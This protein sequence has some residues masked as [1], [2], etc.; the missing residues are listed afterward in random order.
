MRYTKI[1]LGDKY[2]QKI[3]KYREDTLR[4]RGGRRIDK[5]E[6]ESQIMLNHIGNV[7][8]IMEKMESILF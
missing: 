1:Y 4:E 5:L 7:S 2:K 3:G 6:R 8:K